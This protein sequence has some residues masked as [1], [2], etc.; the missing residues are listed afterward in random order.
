MKLVDWLFLSQSVGKCSKASFNFQQRWEFAQL[1][2]D[3][4]TT[5]VLYSGSCIPSDHTV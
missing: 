4:D 1:L 5:F 3:K 2:F